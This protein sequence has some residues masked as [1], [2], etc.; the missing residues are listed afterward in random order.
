VWNIGQQ[1]WFIWN[2]PTPGSQ[3]HKARLE[4]L[5]AKKARKGKLSAKEEAELNEAT[6]GAK[7]AKTDN[8]SESES[9]SAEE[10]KQLYMQRQN[11]RAREK[12]QYKNG[13]NLIL[14]LLASLLMLLSVIAFDVLGYISNKEGFIQKAFYFREY[15][16]IL[17]VI[18]A[19]SLFLL[20]SRIEFH[21]SFINVIAGTILG[22]Y[23]IHDNS[24]LRSYIWG[25][26]FPNI[27]YVESPYLHSIIKIVAVFVICV[28][29]EI[30]RK[31][32]IARWLCPKFERLLEKHEA[33]RK[34]KKETKIENATITVSSTS[35]PNKKG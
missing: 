28:A 35:I 4:R 31:N 16:M 18:C 27:N 6:S 9:V 29:I 22:V 26:W 2:N 25:E 24:I 7:R 12:V 34:K 1:A 32:L 14:A 33:N 17:P 11:Q 15:N 20:F 19:I 21:N 8:A 23:I 5:R 30:I 10:A 13:I 3:A